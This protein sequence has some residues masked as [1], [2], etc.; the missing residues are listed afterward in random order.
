MI[1]Y[2]FWFFNQNLHFYITYQEVRRCHEI[3]M[4]LKTHIQTA[5]ALFFRTDAEGRS[6]TVT[7]IC[8]ERACLVLPVRMFVPIPAAVKDN[9]DPALDRQDTLI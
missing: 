3:M 5:T 4:A 2:Y 6:S 7:Q 9:R 1:P 8:R